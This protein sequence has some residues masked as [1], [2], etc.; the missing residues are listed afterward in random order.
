MRG[1]TNRGGRVGSTPHVSF[2][3]GLTGPDQVTTSTP[4]VC[5]GGKERFM[6]KRWGRGKRVLCVYETCT[7]TQTYPVSSIWINDFLPFSTTV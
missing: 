1:Q 3:R 5:C 6:E 2:E 4:D 7:S